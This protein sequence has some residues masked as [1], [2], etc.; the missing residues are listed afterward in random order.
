MSDTTLRVLLIEDDED[1]FVLT[2]DLLNEVTG[3]KYEITWVSKYSDALPAICSGNHD[4]CLIDYRLGEG[5]G[6]QLV[7]E[8]IAADCLV[9]MIL[10]TGQGGHEIDIEATQAGAADYLI[11][12]QIESLLLE[13]AIRYAL[14]RGK[15][16][17]TL[18]ESENRFRSVV[19]SAND[20]I[21]LT[22]ESGKISAWN[23]GAQKIFG[24]TRE[25]ILGQSLS[26]LF[27]ERYYEYLANDGVTDPLISSGLLHANGKTSE[28]NGLKKDETEFPL[29]I[30]LS[31]W[32]TAKGL[33]YSGI[34]R[35]VTERK[36][37]E[38]QLTH[39]ALHD[40]LTK[41]ANR[42]LFRDRVE[43][44]LTRVGRKKAPVAVLFLDLDNFKNINDS[45]GHAAGDQLLISVA[46]RLQACLRS[47]DT[48]ARLGGDEFAILVEDS[49]DTN[50]AQLV[51]ERIRDILRTPFSIAGK[52]ISVGTSI[53]IASAQTGKESPEE[54]LR[55]AD[56]AMYMAKTHGKGCFTVF[57]TQMHEA[58]V[59]RVELE[60]DMRR[61][62]ERNEFEVYY[63]PIV[64]LQ[65]GMV[66]GMEALAR[67][68][69]PTRGMVMPND[70]IPL[71][72]ET[73]L[74]IP[75]GGY[76]LEEACRQTRLWQDQKECKS[77]LSIT[78]N[79]SGCQFQDDSLPTTIADVLATTGLNPNSL[80]LEITENT[81][82]QNTDA[83]VKKLEDLKALGVRLAIDDFGTGYSS[84]SYLQ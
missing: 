62:I 28:Y 69:H 42:V 56:V 50:G 43:H 59:L 19:E 4:I 64:D 3:T 73:K 27:P 72:E 61:A 8:A 52:E 37:L 39:Q 75:I 10:L 13:R 7:R 84:L 11:K 46:D 77:L 74:I 1:D 31:S 51:A 18:R 67:W 24:Y 58:L 60:D 12:G 2:S 63:Q 29:E 15:M 23:N 40:P 66:M 54:L 78:V 16:L 48:A 47:S 45:L 9:P 82:L 55:N 35:D 26:I 83:S 38:D 53:G 68:N 57:E 5:N 30:S 33:F 49:T 21:I 70:F 76:I 6:I 71:A 36:S 44:S 32:E 20:A 41:L 22:D 65:S 80:I 79:I 34:I 17:E 81:M 25:D 14:A